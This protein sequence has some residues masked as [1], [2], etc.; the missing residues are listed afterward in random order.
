MN[1]RSTAAVA[2]LVAALGGLTLAACQ[3]E[4]SVR[5]VMQTYCALPADSGIRAVVRE[6]LLNRLDA[7][8]TDTVIGDYTV[9]QLRERIETDALCEDVETYL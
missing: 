8:E 4:D 5:G 6:R 7:A 3:V 2:V 9:D 1:I